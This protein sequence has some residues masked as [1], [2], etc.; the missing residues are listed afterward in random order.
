MVLSGAMAIS[1]STLGFAQGSATTTT[2][3]KDNVHYNIHQRGEQNTSQSGSGN[4]S[5][6]VLGSDNQTSQTQQQ[7]AGNSSTTTTQSGT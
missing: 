2:D 1:F 3:K 6:Q 7:G 4:Q 5:S